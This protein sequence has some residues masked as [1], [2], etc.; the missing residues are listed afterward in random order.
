ML[1]A[2]SP[3]QPSYRPMPKI[4]PYKRPNHDLSFGTKLTAK[5][6]KVLSIVAISDMLLITGLADPFF[7]LL[8]PEILGIQMHGLFSPWVDGLMTIGSVTVNMICLLSYKIPGQ[9]K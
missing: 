4:G 7:H 8:K 2:I 5:D 6:K 9:K 3:V 1:S